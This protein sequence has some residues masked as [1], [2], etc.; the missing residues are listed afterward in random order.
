M[1]DTGAT[2]GHAGRRG[3]RGSVQWWLWGVGAG[4]LLWASPVLAQVTGGPV[5]LVTRV[6]GVVTLAVGAD[7]L[8]A[9]DFVQ[10]VSGELY[11]VQEG[12]LIE[13]VYFGDG[14]RE[15][16]AGPARMV[17]R[18]TGGT[19]LSGTPQ[20]SFLP[21]SAVAALKKVPP[22]GIATAEARAGGNRVRGLE[23][24]APPA[25]QPAGSPP[26]PAAPFD[27]RAA[28]EAL[29]RHGADPGSPVRPGTQKPQPTA[30]QAGQAPAGVSLAA[31][32]ARMEGPAAPALVAAA[33]SAG[34]AMQPPAA[35]AADADVVFRAAEGGALSA[36]LKGGGELVAARQEA[37]P[38][39]VLGAARMCRLQRLSQP[40]PSRTISV[41]LA[42][43]PLEGGGPGSVQEPVSVPVGQQMVIEMVNDSALP[44]QIRIVEV[45]PSGSV[46]QVFPPADK[47][48]GLQPYGR[49][50]LP[51]EFA[52][53]PPLGA[54]GYAL[55]ATRQP[56]PVPPAAASAPA[57]PPAADPLAAVLQSKNPAAA[58]TLDT[59]LAWGVGWSRLVIRP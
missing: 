51:G 37:W 57:A 10:V 44:V 27:E 30:G 54:Y 28:R 4:V 41:S 12:G 59:G 18:P 35:L 52:A 13:L 31:L 26:P 32:S 8:P 56:P 23:P 58:L 5:G 33:T 55:V 14:R 42:V 49:R 29:A 43:F 46:S 24:G 11:V 19:A 53:A 36:R 21:A 15:R 45:G 6:T 48:E 38:E 39:L 7:A 3:E 2:G 50:R 40:D 22:R 16:W 20:V 34:F 17:V 47:V 1:N 9:A 25:A